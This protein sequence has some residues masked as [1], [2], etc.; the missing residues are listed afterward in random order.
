MDKH[1]LV[2]L[3]IQAVA[4][5]AHMVSGTAHVQARDHTEDPDRLASPGDG[6]GPPTVG[7]AQLPKGGV[8]ALPPAASAGPAARPGTR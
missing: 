1:G 6:A 5:E 2:A 8:L 3:R 4:E 7:Y